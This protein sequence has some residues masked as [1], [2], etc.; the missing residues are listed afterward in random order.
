MLSDSL[1]SAELA[2]TV[3]TFLSK[4]NTPVRKCVC[5]SLLFACLF[6]SRAASAACGN[7]IAL[8]IIFDLLVQGLDLAAGVLH[9]ARHLQAAPGREQKDC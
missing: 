8:I 1:L 3:W 5:V 7:C 4:K 9:A 6:V 2:W